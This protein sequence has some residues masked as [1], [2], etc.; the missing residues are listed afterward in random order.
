MPV[1]D[2]SDMVSSVSFN[3]SNLYD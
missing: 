3:T 1:P 2:N